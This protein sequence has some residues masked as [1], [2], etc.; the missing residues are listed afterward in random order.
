MI[1]AAAVADFRPERTSDRKIKKEDIVEASKRTLRKNPNIDLPGLRERLDLIYSWYE[2]VGK[3]DRFRL[4]YTPGVGSELFFNGR[5]K[6]VIPGD[7]FAE[8]Y[9]GIWVSDYSLSAKYQKRL[10]GK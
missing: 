10:L 5:S 3:G 6:G 2:N 7:D 9:F 8:A 4:D 1:K